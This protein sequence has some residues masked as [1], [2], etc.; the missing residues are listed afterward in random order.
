M[1]NSDRRKRSMHDQDGRD[2]IILIPYV[3]VNGTRTVSD[4]IILQTYEKMAEDGTDNTVFCDGAVTDKEEFLDYLKDPNNL[5]IFA[6]Y[7]GVISGVGWINSLKRNHAYVHFVLFKETWG[8]T[9]LEIGW[10]AIDYWFS[11]PGE[12]GPLFDV[13]LGVI[14]KTNE[15]ALKYIEKIGFQKG[16]EIPQISFVNGKNE[17]AII[18][19]IERNYAADSI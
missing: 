6:L 11:I 9:S 12:D 17:T 3:E 14:P 5:F 2:G 16:G 15:K 10:K 19:Y 13:L 1:L 18:S 8:K 4:E 7:K